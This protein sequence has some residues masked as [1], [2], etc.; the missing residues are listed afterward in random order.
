MNRQR[1][2]K[3]IEWTRVKRVID[4]TLVELPGYTWNPTGGCL[5]GCT[6]KMPDGSVT[7][8]YAKT[9]AERL[10][11]SAYSQGFEHHYWRPHALKEPLQLKE[12]AG[13]FVG[14]MADLFGHWVPAE[15]IR[16]VMDVMEQAHW[17]TFQTLSKY[18][19][20]LVE[21]NPFPAN[22]W[23]GVSLPAGHLM[24]LE[25]GA[26]AL[27]AYLRHMEQIE[28]SIRFMSIEPL[29]F[30]VASVFADWLQS[31][32][33]LPFEWVIIGAASSGRSIFQP[34][35]DWVQSLLDIFD[36]QQLPV[37]FKG[38][39]KWHKW[40][41]DFPQNASIRLQEP[42]LWPLQSLKTALAG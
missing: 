28:A 18:P 12:P 15:Q 40:R 13:I 32:E 19:V 4:G 24:K 3:G 36:A 26:R 42:Q 29:W 6:W 41:G 31:H 35:A 20:R 22:V 5:H 38:N 2:P 39:L 1:P 14:S 30:D 17:H 37:F 10:A 33:R 27:K 21:F 34:K 11:S 8:C 25:G 9:V 7:E 23:V 16:E